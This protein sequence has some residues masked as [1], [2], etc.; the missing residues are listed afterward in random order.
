MSRYAGGKWQ[1]SRGVRLAAISIA[2]CIAV[3]GVADAATRA[4]SAARS[5]RSRAHDAAAPLVV[6]T[7]SVSR[8]GTILVND[9]G[10]T[11]Y[12]FAPDKHKKVTCKGACA[13]IWPPLKLASG[14]KVVAKG[15]AMQKKLGSD[16]DPGGGRVVTYDG[17]PLY[18]YVSDTRAGEA[19]GQAINLNGGL[20]YVISPSG[21]VVRHA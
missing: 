13:A 17:W 6:S 14:Q 8:V 18:T 16:P 1:R 4:P 15:K 5:V 3:A 19:T 7:R 2:A 20:W 10:R 11:L 21:N 12:I 9:Q